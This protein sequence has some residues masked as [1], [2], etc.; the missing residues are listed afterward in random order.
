MRLQIVDR[1]RNRNLRCQEAL[2]AKKRSPRGKASMYF[3]IHCCTAVFFALFLAYVLCLLLGGILFAKLMVT[4]TLLSQA[5]AARSPS[6]FLSNA[7]SSPRNTTI[8]FAAFGIE[9]TS[10]ET[11]V[12]SETTST[13]S[14][15]SFTLVGTAAPYA[16]W[17]HDGTQT[18][19]VLREH[20]FDGYR[21]QEV[22]TDQ[23][24]FTK[25]EERFTLFLRFAS[26]A[27]VQ[28]T[29]TQQPVQQMP[30]PPQ[31]TQP[32]TPAEG[33]QHAAFNGEDGA[34]ARELLN[35]LLMNPYAEIAKV[36]LVPTDSGMMVRNIRSDSL[37]N[38]LGVQEGDILTGIN[39]I[40][41]S[42]VGNLSNAI[43]SML[44]GARL[45][46]NIDRNN[47]SG[48]LGYVVQ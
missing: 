9:D 45:D 17:L 12:R 10:P 36:R 41:I 29:D 31:P 46:F 16:A 1:L 23:A 15:G 32:A 19:L 37:L 5:I 21:L 4:Q 14:I 25:D 39:G 24:L 2:S 40:P 18:S 33:V 26:S 27:T 42:D 38:Q 30:A 35:E 7:A 13:K 47:E 34:I 11:A 8:G 48:R 20:E 43:N 6:P 28:K 3:A 44:T 22:R